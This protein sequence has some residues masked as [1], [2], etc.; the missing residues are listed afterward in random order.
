MVCLFC[1]DG[2]LG[3]GRASGGVVAT[4]CY[5]ENMMQPV[6][7]FSTISVTEEAV[8]GYSRNDEAAAWRTDVLGAK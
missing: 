3:G 7:L 2:K 4:T 8:F 1:I 5:E 6:L